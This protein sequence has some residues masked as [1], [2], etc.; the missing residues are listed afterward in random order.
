MRRS[1]FVNITP[2]HIEYAKKIIK[3]HGNCYSIKCK[4]CPFYTDNLDVHIRIMKEYLNIYFDTSNNTLVE[5]CKDF[6][7]LIES[8]VL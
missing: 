6:L 2:K 8:E 5:M 1:D 3:E 4:D 7:K